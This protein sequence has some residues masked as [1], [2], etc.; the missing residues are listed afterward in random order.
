MTTRL[1]NLRKVCEITG[2]SRSTI[3]RLMGERLFPRPVRI[4]LRNNGWVEAEIEAHL[5]SRIADRDGKA[6]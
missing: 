2:Q 5:A 4:G 6:A 3:Y 1:L